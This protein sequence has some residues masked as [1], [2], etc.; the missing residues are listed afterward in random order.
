[1]LIPVELLVPLTGLIGGIITWLVKRLDK[2]ETR[3]EKQA[4]ESLQTL[5]E[6]A[7][8]AERVPDLVAD[9]QRLQQRVAD[10]ER[11]S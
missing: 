11:R 6:Q 8:L 9:N 7:K 5:R 2:V 10:L 1:M 4:E 3:L